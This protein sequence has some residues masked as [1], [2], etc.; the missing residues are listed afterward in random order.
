MN[1]LTCRSLCCVQPCFV[2]SGQR[3][4]I[5]LILHQDPLQCIV[6]HSVLL[7]VEL[8]KFLHIRGARG[9]TDRP[10]ILCHLRTKQRDV[11]KILINIALYWHII[12]GNL[13]YLFVLS[14]YLA[15]NEKYCFMIFTVRLVFVD[16]SSLSRITLL[17]GC[18][19]CSR[20][21]C[22]M[23]EI[24]VGKWNWCW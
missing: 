5:T 9:R 19:H 16:L 13:N 12:W 1:T 6:P 10:P 15:R 8:D 3:D 21:N 24:F 17:P 14:D 23:A 18:R 20:S 2:N 4:V 11:T 22:S 7:A